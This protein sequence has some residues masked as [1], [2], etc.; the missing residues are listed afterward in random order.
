MELP[1]SAMCIDCDYFL[2]GLDVSVCPECGRAFDPSD[3]TTFQHPSRPV[4]WRRWAKAPSLTQAVPAVALALAYSYWS[5]VPG[6]LLA[7]L[8]FG[9][10]VFDIAGVALAGWLTVDYIRRVRA[11]VKDRGRASLDQS[12]KRD[13]SC[14]RWV[15]TPLCL[16]VLVSGIVTSWPL[17]RR[18]ELSRIAFEDVIRKVESGAVPSTLTGRIGLM[19]VRRIIRYGTGGVY[20]QTG[21]S[22]FDRVGLDFCSS[23]NGCQYGQ[24]ALHRNWAVDEY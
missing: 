18:F 23:D 6:G 3:A 15:A 9:V 20:F 1:E 13:K 5:S 14:F 12:H 17:R 4:G 10:I 21:V 11:A 22:G 16:A 2:R 19:P 7:S 24:T 8:G